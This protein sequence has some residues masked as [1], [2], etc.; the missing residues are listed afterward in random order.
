[1][2][3]KKVASKSSGPAPSTDPAVVVLAAGKGTRMNSPIPKVLHPLMGR[4]II[5]H[6]LNAARYLKP[7]RLVV[8]TG[9]GADQVEEKIDSF[10][11]I[12]ARQENPQGTGQAVQTATKELKDFNGPVVILPGDVPLISPQ[13]LLDFLDAHKALGTRLS[14]LTCRLEDPSGYGRIIRD[15]NGWLEKIVEDKDASPQELTINEINS[16]IYVIDCQTLKDNIFNIKNNN[17][18]KEFYL[19]DIVA[20]VRAKGHLSSAVQS[21]DHLEVQGINDCRELAFAQTV[22]RCRV[23][24]SWLFSGVV[25]DDPATTYIE[26]SVKL[27]GGVH[28]EPGVILTGNT[29]VGAKAEIGAYCHLNNVELDEM[30]KLAPHMTLNDMR[31]TDDGHVYELNERG[32]I[33]GQVFCQNGDGADDQGPQSFAYASKQCDPNIGPLEKDFKGAA[34]KA[35]KKPAAT[36][37]APKKPAPKKPAPKKTDSKKSAPN[38]PV[39]NFSAAAKA[40]AP[41]KGGGKKDPGQSGPGGH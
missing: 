36:K 28:L 12:F 6:V 35:S 34:V 10:G 8:V 21:P 26:P 24:D 23:N 37:T 20:E 16:S 3:N 32:E 22:L 14:V 38:K 18:Q 40:K 9:Y 1:M 15:K 5:A 41:A 31:F 4:P 27:A 13:T 33:I 39:I 17:A 30:V 25:M 11:A 29:K 2:A 19:T 7:A